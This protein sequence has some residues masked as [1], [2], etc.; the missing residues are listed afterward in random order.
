MTTLTPPPVATP[1]PLLLDGGQSQHDLARAVHWA[2][3]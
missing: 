2:C 3:R 1:A